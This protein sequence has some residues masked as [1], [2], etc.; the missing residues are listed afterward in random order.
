MAQSVI[1][2]KNQMI[3]Q[4]EI[5]MEQHKFCGKGGDII[6]KIGYQSKVK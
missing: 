2:C 6:S 4:V 1:V 5:D 3:S